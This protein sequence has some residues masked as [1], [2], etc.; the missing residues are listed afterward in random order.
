MI[1][2]DKHKIYES[3]GYKFINF[4]D[5]TLAQKEMILS[6]RNHEKVRSMM[7]NKEIISFEDHLNFIEGLKERTDCYYWL[8][9]DS[10]GVEIGVFDILHVD[11]QKD[12][13]EIGYYLNPMEVGNGFEF[14]IECNF[15]A[16]SIVQLGNNMVTINA[17]NQ[18]VLMFYSYLGGKFE[19]SE[20]IGDEIF[21]INK[22]A[23]GE[24]MV[25]NYDTFSLKDF[26]RFVRKNRHF[27]KYNNYGIERF[28]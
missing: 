26:A 22:H 3:H 18:E 10:T 9:F 28:Y 11:Y 23:T 13:G 16:Y 5:L 14:V 21:F 19:Y 12:Q 2:V 4:V 6:W 8:V 27:F 15:F 24:Y 17:K 20:Q 1:E 7:V 25:K